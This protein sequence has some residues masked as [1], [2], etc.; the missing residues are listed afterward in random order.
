MST[1]APC[2]LG[3]L[4]VLVTRPAEQAAEFAEKVSAAHGRPVS[5]P[6]L[7]I[8]G[9]PDK[10]AAR[11]RLAGLASVHVLVFVSANAVR[12]AYP[13]MPDDIPLNL[14]IAA[15]G[16]ATARALEEVGLDPTLVPERMDSEGLL[17]LPP[18]QSMAGR[19]VLIVRGNG[20]RETLRETLQARGAQVD[21]VEVYRRRV[22]Q[23][24]PANLVRN[25]SRLVDVV[26]ATS[27][28]IL[29]N[30]FTLL[31]TEGGALLQATPLVVPSQRI[32]E[33]AAGR[34]CTRVTVADSATDEDMLRALC[35]LAGSEA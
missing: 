2:N 11:A 19:R 20:G 35:G 34:G 31:G 15:V 32:A 9:P 13:L 24:N 27:A 3:G 26:T 6:A 17:A 28:Q 12:Y 8:L 7:E 16:A 25:W 18:L 1:N 14:Q 4:N 30:L 22:P 21:Y 5:F 29:D 33:H 10:Q 23:R